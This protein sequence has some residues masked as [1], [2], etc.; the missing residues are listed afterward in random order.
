MSNKNNMILYSLIKL[1]LYYETNTIW[2]N[3]MKPRHNYGIIYETKIIWNSGIPIENF[4][5]THNSPPP[6]RKIY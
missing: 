3:I 6:N 1:C 2:N 4:D 5:S